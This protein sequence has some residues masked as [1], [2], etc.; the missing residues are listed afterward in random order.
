MS[1]LRPR[2][3]ELGVLGLMFGGEEVAWRTAVADQD[4]ILNSVDPQPLS[5]KYPKPSTL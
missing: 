4:E 1:V 3:F 2:G 5:P